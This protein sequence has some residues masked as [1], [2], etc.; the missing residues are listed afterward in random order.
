MPEMLSPAPAG[1]PTPDFQVAAVRL[2]SEALGRGR[3]VRERAMAEARDQL[4]KGSR[5]DGRVQPAWGVVDGG[6]H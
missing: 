1:P 5:E 6:G 2:P 3:A 4:E